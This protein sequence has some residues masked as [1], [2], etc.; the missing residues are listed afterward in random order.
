MTEASSILEK[1]LAFV[2][3]PWK[4]VTLVLLM[5]VSLALYIVYEERAQI[6]DAILHNEVKPRLELDRFTRDVPR[7]LRDTHSDVA[8]LAELKLAN[9]TA[10]DLIGFDSD[11]KPWLP[12]PGPRLVFDSDFEPAT[13]T[14]FAQFMMNHPVCFDVSVDSKSVERQAEA[15]LG[16]KRA[17]IVAVPPI[18]GVLIG[19]L[20]V[21]WKQP[22]LPALERKAT[23]AMLDAAM[24]YATW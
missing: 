2:D 16:I 10:T 11:G 9:N 3:R 20:Y 17:C 13:S 23:A 8:M 4:A 22:P 1:L 18:I 5:V 24:R 12:L 19:G 7:L 15:A 6:A 21:G 14:A